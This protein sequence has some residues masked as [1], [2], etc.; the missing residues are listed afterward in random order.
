MTG[1]SSAL[2]AVAERLQKL[3]GEQLS[4]V[5]AT[6]DRDDVRIV[7]R[8]MAALTQMGFRS[9]PLAMAMRFDPS[10]R[11]YPYTQLLSDKFVDA[12]RGRSTRQIWNLPARYGKSLWASKWG[13]TWA[14]DD[15]PTLPLMLASYGDALANENATFVRDA[16]VRHSD[17]LSC[18]L[19]PD[20]RRMDRFVTE[21]G[22]GLIAAGIGS[23]LTGFGA[24]GGVLDDPFKNWQD[25]HSEAIRK[26]VWNWYRSVFRLRLDTETAW[27]IVVMTRWH[28]EDLTGMLTNADA[29]GD[30]EQW[31]HVVLPAIAE[32][33]DLLGRA[34]GEPLEPLRFSLAEVLQ[35]ARALGSYLSSGLEQQHPTPEEGTDIMRGWWKWFEIAPPRFDDATTSW[36]MKLKDKESGD[37]V[38]GQAWGRTGSNFWLL[39]QLR[40]QWN[41]VQTKT[42]IVLMHVRHPYIRKHV[43]ENTGNGPEVM[44]ELRRPQPGYVVSEEVRSQL[45]I[46]DAELDRVNAVFRR[47]MSALLPENVKFDKRVRM[48]AQAGLIEGGGVHVPLNAVGESVVDECSAFPNGAHDD[49][50]DALSQALKRLSKGRGSAVTPKGKIKS[51]APGARSTRVLPSTIRRR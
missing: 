26:R 4:E 25:A 37:Y 40:G 29:L 5:L 16:L 35:R 28:E 12:V 36:D 39:D 8:A 42:A 7:E 3:S 34:V 33:D 20:R 47:G 9:S 23:A 50:V 18:T 48:R 45:G 43:I 38:V 19:K 6:L 46:T 32:A 49:Q 22:G 11:A 14:M 30:G 13:P 21:Q 17:V 10:I 1:A 51:P 24:R 27:L 41:Q 2:D 31:E 44:E 15:D